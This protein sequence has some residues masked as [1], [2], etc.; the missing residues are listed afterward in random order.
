MSTKRRDEFASLAIPKFDRLV[1]TR[2]RQVKS[3]W[4]EG[5]LYYQ[6]LMASHSLQ[7]LVGLLRLPHDHGVVVR[8]GYELLSLWI[9]R[10]VVSRKSILLHLLGV[11]FERQMLACVIVRA[12]LEDV[13][14]AE[15]Q[16]VDPMG[17]AFQI[18]EENA[19]LRVPAFDGSILACGVDDGLASPKNLRHGTGVAGEDP[20]AYEGPGVP[21]PRRHVFGARCHQPLILHL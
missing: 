12:S 20:H 21:Y 4:R 13:V 16:S 10:F 19:C 9:S 5:H 14:G 15:G 3:I 7:G 18:V 17:M 2:T 8:A 11:I 6:T 1:K